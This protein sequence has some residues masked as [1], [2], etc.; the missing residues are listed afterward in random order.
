MKAALN[1]SRYLLITGPTGYGKTREAGVL[2]QT[3]MLE[4]WRVLQIKTGWL[5]IPK[6]LPEELNSNRSRVLI[7][8]DDLNG[9]FSTGERT[10][11]PRAEQMPLLF[12]MRYHDRLLQMLNMFEYMC[13][14]NEIRV[15]ATAR[16]EADQWKLLDFD[17]RDK[18]WKQFKRIEI[19]EPI[20]TAIVNLLEDATKQANLQS[21]E[22]EFEAIA[23]ES[24]GTYRNILLN[25]RRFRSQNK[26]VSKD[27][28]TETLDG[29]WR[30]IYERTLKKHPAAKYIYDAID[31]LQQAGIDLLPFLVEATAVEIWGGNSLQRLS[32]LG[33]IKFVL[34]YLTHQTNT[35]RH[36]KNGL[37]PADGQIEGKGYSVSWLLYSRQLTHLLLNNSDKNIGD[38]LYGLSV[39]CDSEKQFEQA[40][41][42]INQYIRLTP[43]DF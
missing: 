24:D 8:L 37:T 34:K 29:S 19:D 22:N 11:S 3:M 6:S 28:F 13:T 32:R 2:A 21:D 40:Y 1:S 15:I 39:A 12:Q 10:Q 20:D 38:S 17:E 27:D 33:K 42:L 35:L 26:P 30:E 14:E 43:L 31:V 16:S 25:L 36:T 5:D 7:F 9:L 41:Q 4:G 18:L 23:H